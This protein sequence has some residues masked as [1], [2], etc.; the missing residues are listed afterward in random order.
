MS[1]PICYAPMLLPVALLR[2][3]AASCQPGFDLGF[4]L[5]LQILA[6]CSREL[7][8]PHQGKRNC[9]PLN[10]NQTGKINITAHSQ[11]L[12]TAPIQLQT[13]C[14][15][16]CKSQQ[17]LCCVTMCAMVAVASYDLYKKLIIYIR[18]SKTYPSMNPDVNVGQPSQLYQD[19][20]PAYHPR[21]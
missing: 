17:W 13:R 11:R 21:V 7:G 6:A 12:I 16:S 18:I 5:D 4:D 19:P 10:L 9:K 2:E 3:C 1:L 20:R 15:A 14:C 8:G